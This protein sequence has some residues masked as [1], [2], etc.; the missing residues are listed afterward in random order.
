MAK[1]SMHYLFGLGSNVGERADNIQQAVNLM[2]SNDTLSLTKAK[3][4]S[5]YSSPA[6]LPDGAPKEWNI[7]FLNGILSVFSPLEPQE[8]LKHVQII[9]QSLGKV[10][11]GHWGPREIDIDILTAED[12]LIE[13]YQLTLPHRH[14][15]DRNFVLIPLAE[16]APAWEHPFLEL[17]AEQMLDA[18]G[19]GAKHLTKSPKTITLST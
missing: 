17:T 7:P 4:S 15:A 1:R 16:I 12:K 10:K 8:M 3:I 5:L 6:M 19:D 14:I 18:L 13:T 9:E 11:R 2:L